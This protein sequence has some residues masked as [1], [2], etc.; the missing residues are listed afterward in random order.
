MKRILP[1]LAIVLAA[2]AQVR[3]EDILKGPGN[4]WLTY[5]GDYQAKR[6]SPL[7]QINTAN[8]ANVVPK[9]AYHVPKA[10]GLRT[11]PIVYDGVMYITN[12]NELRALD[13]KSGRLIWAYKDSRSKKE[14][15]NRGAAIL[16]D[17][18]FFV[19]ADIQAVALDRRTG[20]VIWQKKYGNIDEGMFASAAPL[21]LKDKILVGVAG[22]DTGMRGYIA[23]LNADTGEEMWRTYTI[24]AKGEPGSESWGKYIQY[25]GGGTWLSGT[26]DPELNLIYWTTG[27]PWPDFYGADRGG[28][29]LY[30]CSLIAL[31]ADTGKMK[32]YFQFTPH[33][34]HDWDAQS[35]PVLIDIPINGKP[36]KAVLHANRNGFFYALDRVTGEYLRATRLVEK[37]DWASGIDA[38][39]R[40]ILVPDKDPTPA[41]NRV[42]PGVRGATN[43]MS[44][45]YNPSTGWFY[46]ITLEQCDIFTSSSKE[47]E[48]MKNFSGGGAGPKPADIGQFVVR[49]FDPKTGNKMWEYPMTGPAEQWSGTVSTAGGLIFIGDDD[50][51]LIA[52][53]ARTG[54]H[55]WHFNM[56]EGLTAAPIVYTVDG[57]EQISIASSTAIWAFGLPEAVKSAPMPKI[58]LE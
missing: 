17:K 5:A 44:P 43:W 33:D 20:A 40:P 22:G 50:G 1:S 21:A 36:R 46:V 57:K 51:Q 41:G 14:A 16:G 2:Q 52:L 3:Y 7:T 32:W 42:C 38:K 6:H 8:V 35:W 25:G 12:T 58:R 27:N 13:A 11:N 15:V 4:N 26:F 53:D 29:N 56:G 31:D 49:A 39:G 54:K 28:D 9:W 47:P 37:L 55:L 45:S 23:A 10:N 19:T 48:P 24:P 34:T 18:V 30:S